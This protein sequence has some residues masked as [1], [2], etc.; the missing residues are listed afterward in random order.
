MRVVG[1]GQLIMEGPLHQLDAAEDAAPLEESQG[2]IDGGPG[3]PPAPALQ[4][5]AE[6]FGVEVAGRL[7]DGLNYQPARLC[8]PELVRRQ[9]SGPA[10]Q[11]AARLTGIGCG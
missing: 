2:P 9:E 10:T 7:H 3:E 5:K 11:G 8:D 6:G 1:A 4:P